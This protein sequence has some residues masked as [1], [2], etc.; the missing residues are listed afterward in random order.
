MGEQLQRNK[1][2][3]LTRMSQTYEGQREWV[4]I[5]IKRNSTPGISEDHWVKKKKSG[6]YKQNLHVQ[7]NTG[8]GGSV[9]SQGAPQQQHSAALQRHV[10]IEVNISKQTPTKKEDDIFPRKRRSDLKPAF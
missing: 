9:P 2:E 10:P 5:E 7:Y 8:A 4:P 3:S 1:Q 6:Y